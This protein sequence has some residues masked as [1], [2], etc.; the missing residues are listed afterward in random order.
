MQTRVHNASCARFFGGDLAAY[1]TYS[2]NADAHAAVQVQLPLGAHGRPEGAASSTG[3]WRLLRTPAPPPP[4]LLHPSRPHENQISKNHSNP[5]PSDLTLRC[6]AHTH[7]AAPAGVLVPVATS[8][9][10][11]LCQRRQPARGSTGSTARRAP[12]MCALK[13]EARWSGCLGEVGRVLDLGT[14]RVMQRLA[15]SGVLTSV[16]V[17]SGRGGESDGSGRCGGCCWWWCWC[18]C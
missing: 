6:A 8:R 14:L 13:L 3:R 18:W 5:R 9:C 7:T 15:L 17:G 11:A 4:R 10:R 1:N 16:L 12:L 2:A